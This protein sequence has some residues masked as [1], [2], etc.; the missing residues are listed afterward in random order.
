MVDR[1]V[2]YTV[3]DSFLFENGKASMNGV[4]MSEDGARAILGDPIVDHAKRSSSGCLAH[5]PFKVTAV[6]ERDGVITLEGKW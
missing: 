4:P 6:D 3:G 2:K 1:S 5:K